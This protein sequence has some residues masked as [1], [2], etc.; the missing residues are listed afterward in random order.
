MLVIAFK[1]LIKWS[2]IFLAL[3]GALIIWDDKYNDTHIKLKYTNNMKTIMLSRIN[4][5]ADESNHNVEGLKPTLE[6]VKEL[7]P[8]IYKWFYQ[9]HNDENL[10]ITNNNNDDIA[11]YCY[12]TK[13]LFIDKNLFNYTD[14]EKASTIIH[15]Y[16]HSRQSFVK[17]L[18]CGL[19]NNEWVIERDA[20][21]LTAVALLC[22]R[23]PYG[24][25]NEYNSRF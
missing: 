23:Q 14:G 6:I 18:R 25:Y 13:Q 22:L 11:A 10:I 21:N 2:I 17:F 24:A 8:D 4:T 9:T 20:Y 7:N 12:L 1:S 15:E 5:T 3:F 19:S 16:K